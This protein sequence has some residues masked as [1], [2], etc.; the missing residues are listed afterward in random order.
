[1]VL[2]LLETGVRAQELL[3]INVTDIDFIDSS[4]LIRQGKG[5]KPRSVFMGSTAKK[6]L[7][8]HIRNIPD[9]GALFLS[10]EGDRL[11]YG[12]LKEVIKALSQ[13]AGL[14]PQRLHDFRRTYAL[15]SLR[16]GVDIH[17]LSKLM[18]HTSLQVL[19]RYLRQ[20]KVDLGN[21]YKSLID[22]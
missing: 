20:T 9:K 3:D 15:Q 16:N 12:G 13:K 19:S 17:T 10:R 1:M 14:P 8:K 18:G 7:R 22:S 6:N 4:I 5:R 21:A 11:K 2:L